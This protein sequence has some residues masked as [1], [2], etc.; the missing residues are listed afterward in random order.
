MF[1]IADNDQLMKEILLLLQENE[2]SPV[3]SAEVLNNNYLTPLMNNF[4][5]TFNDFDFLERT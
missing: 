4:W 3:R 1:C 2:C 5:E